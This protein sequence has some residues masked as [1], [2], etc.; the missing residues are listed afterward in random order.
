[1][2]QRI[3]ETG[4]ALARGL[5]ELLYPSA[6][7]L[8]GS[9]PRHGDEG[10]ASPFCPACR[11]ALVSDPHATCPRCGLTVGPFTNVAGRCVACR[12]ERF[13][14][15][16]VVRLGHYDGLLRAVVLRLKQ[17]GSEPLGEM[18]GELWATERRDSLRALTADLI[19]PV[20]LHWWRHWRRGHNQSAALAHGLAAVLGLP[21]SS[22]LRR[23]RNTPK[24]TQQTPSA[25]REN[26]RGAFRARRD[27]RLRGRSVLLVDDVVTTGSTASEAAR[28]LRVAGAAR[29]VVA[30]LSRAGPD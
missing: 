13:A 1:M 20:P 11:N 26:V 6:C 4:R 24:Q 9:P 18:I 14:F 21:V 28:A 17:S 22:C 7:L 27:S 3:T 2:W 10:D 30:T 29:V 8:C 12:D 25:R 15:D 16:S 19:V 23:I 5:V